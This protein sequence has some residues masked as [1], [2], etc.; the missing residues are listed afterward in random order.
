MRMTG[1]K[2]QKK[3]LNVPC[4]NNE[5][6]FDLSLVAL[7][8]AMKSFTCTLTGF[9]LF[10]SSLAH[11][12]LHRYAADNLDYQSKF[13]VFL[14]G[15]VNFCPI[16]HGIAKLRMCFR[17]FSKCAMKARKCHIA[18]ALGVLAL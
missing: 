6:S 14:L 1:G 13:D 3:Y 10:S 17:C 7:A 4:T 15:Q 8:S 12:L 11:V 2:H 18:T 16:F 9:H 5:K